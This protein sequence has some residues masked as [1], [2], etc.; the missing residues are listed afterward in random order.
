MKNYSFNLFKREWIES[1]YK[2]QKIGQ[3]SNYNL[4]KIIIYTI[5]LTILEGIGV[6][7]ILPLLDFVNNASSVIEV[8]SSNSRI[9]N[10]IIIII[11][12]LGLP[13]KF[14]ILSIIVGMVIILRQYIGFIQLLIT[15]R[16]KVD[17]EYNLRK[18]IFSSTFRSSPNAIENLGNGSYIELMTRQ[19]SLAASFLTQLVQ[20]IS[21]L[22]LC[23]SYLIIALI[24]SYKVAIITMLI[25]IIVIML[26]YK[27]II[28]IKK[29]AEL[30]MIELKG[31]SK[32][33]SESFLSWKMIKIYNTYNYENERNLKWLQNINNQDFQSQKSYGISRLFITVSII[34]SL[35]VI[36]NFGISYEYIE[37]S[38]LLLF[39]IM[40][41]RLIPI[42]L[43]IVAFQARIGASLISVN[44][45]IDEINAL[46]KD[47][48]HDKGKN[49]FP[50]SGDIFFNDLSFKYKNTEKY[51][52][53][54]FNAT[55]ER[56][57]VTTITGPS[58]VGKTTIIET[59]TRILSSYEGSI[60]INNTDIND[61]LL[62]DYRNNI[63]LLPQVSVIFD[64]TV[65]SNIRYGKS[66]VSDKEVE[67]AAKLANAHEFINELPNKYNTILGERGNSLS[68]GQIQRIVLARLLV[69]DAKILILDEPTSSLDFVA[70]NKILE[71]LNN[72]KKTN[73]YTLIIVSHSKD[74]INIGDK[75][76]KLIKIK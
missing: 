20:Y 4:I 30:N 36:L 42:V 26:S 22:L 45:F 54:N 68:G 70:T 56:N 71:A 12:Y 7:L 1:F 37:T 72:I 18:E 8:N 23:F 55:I 41:L 38:T 46:N 44:R 15:T 31:F 27:V 75:S 32:Y 3:I 21:S 53:K 43:T 16:I 62:D 66:D 60:K 34:A 47:K 61:I 13:V 65:S 35:L 28:R 73:K 52:L 50:I 76:I 63:S 29:I 25:G 74:V 5:L 6:T 17:C 49:L 40:C 19:T 58:G 57:K 14:L 10:Y 11:D 9:T 69:S 64:D 67:I 59:L 24:V 33:L 51:V 39:S 48:E 2:F